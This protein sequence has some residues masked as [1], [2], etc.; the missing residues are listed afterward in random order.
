MDIQEKDQT[1]GTD[2]L[3]ILQEVMNIAFGRAAADLAKFI[4]IFV[5]LSV[6]HISLIS[7]SEIGST[8]HSKLEGM[9][10]NVSVVRQDFWGDLSCS[11]VLIFPAHTE[12]EI[13]SIMGTNEL[14]VEFNE[15]STSLAQETLLELGNILI[16]ACAGK[17]AQLLETNVSFTPPFAVIDEPMGEA[18]EQ[19]ELHESDQILSLQT[20]F[21]FEERDVSGILLIAGHKSSF[22][23]IKE[24]L[25]K[26]MAQYE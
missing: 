20:Q 13:I 9:N 15:I 14:K 25:A 4:N 21:S 7:K 6:P 23:W 26:F 18:I 19:M 8:L 3:E 10:K 12:N 11:A 17:I 5:N 1:L 2:D 24:A 16:G 22:A